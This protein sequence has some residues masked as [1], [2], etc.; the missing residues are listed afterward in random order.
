[1]KFL[2]PSSQEAPST[3]VA[4]SNGSSIQQGWTLPT[5]E[6]PDE[7]WQQISKSQIF[8]SNP[9]P[10]RIPGGGN[11][12]STDERNEGGEDKDYIT[13]TVISDTHS[14]HGMFAGYEVP[15]S[16]LQQQQ[17][18]WGKGEGNSA[19][20]ERNPNFDTKEKHHDRFTTC[21]Y[22]RLKA[23]N[24]S[25]AAAA[26]ASSQRKKN[27]KLPPPKVIQDLARVA[28]MCRSASSSS[29]FSFLEQT[30]PIQKGMVHAKDDMVILP[31]VLLSGNKK[32]VVTPSIVFGTKSATNETDLMT[33]ST[34]KSST[35]QEQEEENYDYPIIPYADILI[36]CGDFTMKGSE[37]EVDSFIQFMAQLPHPHKIVVA[38]NH[39][40]SLDEDHFKREEIKKRWKLKSA[41]HDLPRRLKTQMKR[42]GIIYLEDEGHLLSV[43][44]ESLRGT[45]PIEEEVRL[46]GSPIQ[47]AYHDWAFQIEGGDLIHEHWKRVLPGQLDILI[48]H[49]PPLGRADRIGVGEKQRGEIMCDEAKELNRKGCP[50]LLWEVQNRIH[51][52]LHL[53]GHIHGDARAEDSFDGR[54]LFVNAA[55]A[56]HHNLLRKGSRIKTICL[57][58]SVLGVSQ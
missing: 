8:S 14:K 48:T 29:D 53:F 12:I 35:H 19:S 21:D 36:H 7:I 46:F 24:S 18:Q 4:P 42:E 27:K 6:S 55:V 54:T 51:P 15:L 22:F 11:T 32:S 57:P 30:L 41:P 16:S 13:I 31:V 23:P 28:A 49:G 45:E 39:E 25:A 58:C 20:S 1:M 38:G 5:S 3:V 10:T 26:A 2:K 34:T 40:V 43:R 52:R 17:Q 47:P 33:T 37:S 56:D 50:R 44:K 9:Y